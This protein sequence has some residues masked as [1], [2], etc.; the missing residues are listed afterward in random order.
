[1][2]MERF[3]Y[4]WWTRRVEPS[5]PYSWR[6]IGDAMLRVGPAALLFYTATIFLPA[7]LRRRVFRRSFDA[8]MDMW[9]LVAPQ[10]VV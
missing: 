8:L 9:I 1:M 10:P 4:R 6:R 5:G 2:K 3:V 7:E